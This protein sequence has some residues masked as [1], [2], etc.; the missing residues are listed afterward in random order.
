MIAERVERLRKALRERGLEA[1]IITGTDPHQSEYVSPRWRSREFISGF[2]GSAGTVVITLDEALLWTDSR[3]WIQ[4]KAELDGSPFSLM[5]DGDTGVP[6]PFEWLAAKGLRTG[7]DGSTISISD[8][9]K[10][11]GKGISI[12]ITD[13]LLSSFWNNRPSIPATKAYDVPLQYAGCSREEKIGRIR[14]GLREKGASWTFISSLDDIAWTLNLR[15]SD[16]PYNPVFVSYLFISQDE[17]ILFADRSRFEPELASRLSSAVTI[18]A[19][20]EAWTALR[21]KAAGKGYIAPDRTAATF[22]GI[23]SSFLFGRDISMDLKARKNEAEMEGMRKA[24]LLDGVAYVRFLS[25]LDRNGRY[26]EMELSRMLERE[27][28]KLDGYIEPSFRPISAWKDHGAIVHY[29]ASEKSNAAVEGDGLL[30][31]DTGSQFLFGTT[32]ITR[33]LLFGRPTE[34]ERRD[35]TLVLKG[36]LALARSRF[37]EGTRGVQLDVLA[38][39]FL[40]NEG[41]SFFHGTGHGVGCHLSVHEGPLRISSALIDV[42]LLPGMVVSDEPG[43]YKEGRHGIRIENLVTVIPDRSTE[44]GNF[45]RFETLTLVPYEKDLIDIDLLTD[46]E[47]NQINCYHEV[48]RERLSQYLEGEALGYLERASSPIVR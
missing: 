2:T 42:P 32:D 28:E 18:M 20:E 48:V 5:R 40:W 37:I 30:V 15:A 45:Y 3:Y 7:A 11:E 34:E 23:S 25:S 43:V 14:E 39:Q 21:E 38:K 6:S 16:V 10:L 41:E 17:A 47:I 8:F 46:E 44:F 1:Y 33:T 26:T 36:H 31:L 9:R 12:S 29:S 13:D 4:A 19:Y 24:H 27:R 35:Y 22:I